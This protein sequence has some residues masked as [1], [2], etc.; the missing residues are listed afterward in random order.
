MKR[1]RAVANT[2]KLV[3]VS[4]GCTYSILCPNRDLVGFCHPRSFC[5]LTYPGAQL[6]RCFRK[7]GSQGDCSWPFFMLF[8][9]AIALKKQNW[10]QTLQHFSGVCESPELGAM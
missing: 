3:V 4:Y 8:T 9:V 7:Y 2:P 6:A 1:K 5:R 10:S